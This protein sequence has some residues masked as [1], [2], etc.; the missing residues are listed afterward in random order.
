MFLVFNYFIGLK[1][2]RF[3]EENVSFIFLPQLF[4][5]NF[6]HLKIFEVSD[7]K[8][9]LFRNG[10]VTFKKI[11]LDFLFHYFVT[12]FIMSEIDGNFWINS[13]R[14]FICSLL[15]KFIILGYV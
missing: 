5:R 9:N 12:D 14:L 11:Q 4:Q 10:Y 3:Y 15:M 6:F 2:S 13:F 1:K 8:F 7:F